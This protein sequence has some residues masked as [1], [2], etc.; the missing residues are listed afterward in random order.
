MSNYKARVREVINP[1][2]R[3]LKDW[4]N[5]GCVVKSLKGFCVFSILSLRSGLLTGV[6]VLYDTALL[7][8]K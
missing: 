8:R 2:Y 3:E 1:R 6:D 5:P 4:E 7:G